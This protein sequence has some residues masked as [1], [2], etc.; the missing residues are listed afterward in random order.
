MAD[1]LIDGENHRRPEN[2]VTSD[3]QSQIVETVDSTSSGRKIWQFETNG[4][5]AASPTVVNGTVFVGSRDESLYAVDAATG[6]KEWEFET[7]GRIVSSPMVAD[8]TV[9]L[10]STDKNVY[11]V[12]VATGTEKWSFETDASIGSSPTVVDE[13]LY[14]ASGGDEGEERLYALDASTGRERWRFETDQWIHTSPVVVNGTVFLGDY[15]NIYAI[16]VATGDEEWRFE[17]E[18]RGGSAL[19]V[20]DGTVFFANGGRSV[21]AVDAATGEERWRTVGLSSPSSPTVINETVF[22]GVERPEYGVSALDAATGREKWHFQTEGSVSA[23]TVVDDTVFF[24]SADDNVYAVDATTGEEA[25]RFQTD[26]SVSAPIVV[27]GV[28]FVGSRDQSLY[29]IDTDSTGSSEDSR[30]RLGIRGHHDTWTEGDPVDQPLRTRKTSFDANDSKVEWRF[31]TDGWVYSSPTVVDGTAFVGAG[32]GF[33]GRGESELEEIDDTNL[34]ALNTATGEAEWRFQTDDE[35]QSSAAVTDGTAY[36]GSYDNSVYAVDATT[37]SEQWQFTTGDGVVSSPTVEENVLFIGSLDGNLY[38]VDATTGEEVWRFET[39]AGIY[40]SPTVID[41]T[42]FVGGLDNNIYAVD[43]AEGE[44]QWRFETTAQV[45]SSPTVSDETLF[46]GSIDGNIYA[47]DASTGEEQWQFRTDAGIYSSPTVAGGTVFVGSWDG[48]LYAVDVDTG[49]KEWHFQTNEAINSS[50]TVAGNTV[51]IG[52]RDENVYAIDVRSGEKEWLFKTDGW[53]YSS[54][55]VANGT[56]FVGSRDNNVYALDVGGEG[57]ST[58]SRVRLGTLGH[59]HEWAGDLGNEETDTSDSRSQSGERLSEV[60]YDLENAEHSR[61]VSVS[62][63]SNGTQYV[64]W[65]IP[66]ADPSRRAVVTPDYELVPPE[67]ARDALLTDVWT[68]SRT[69]YWGDVVEQAERERQAWQILEGLSR[70]GD[71]SADVAAA[72]ALAH[73]SPTGALKHKISALDSAITWRQNAIDNPHREQFSKMAE[74]LGTV[75]WARDEYASTASV[76][77]LSSEALEVIEF[78]IDAYDTVDT[79]T[80]VA[81]VAGVVVAVAENTH[82]VTMGLMAGGAI[83]KATAFQMFPAIATSYAVDEGSRL[84]E[85]NARTAAAGVA[86]NTIRLPILRELDELHEQAV[87]GIIDPPDIVRYH[88]EMATQYQIAAAANSAMATYQ[89]SVD[90]TLLGSGLAQIFGSEDIAETAREMTE[91]YANLSRYSLA[92]LGAGWQLGRQR[93]EESINRELA[94]RDGDSE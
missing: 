46:V 10:G 50:P 84:L 79:I 87:A 35:I 66:D 86:H 65:G 78:A 71:V 41:D 76:E 52:S 16:D 88:I 48:K 25:W 93:F 62:S 55:T 49:Q 43:T 30:V 51:F 33:A 37:G 69:R 19:T 63:G 45:G 72:L 89:D 61:T 77:N 34:Y 57:S 70:A 60:P 39:D 3:Q 24:G 12:D 83:G 92:Q 90:D 81:E 40:S 58:G 29:A 91:H 17:T 47:I 68:E 36:I 38:S 73:V 27:D 23:P 94:D 18:S 32:D 6:D 22:V 53:V 21:C 56:L 11:A 2:R 64:L 13:T 5:I 42:V 74:S 80:D 1:R 8:S 75:Q 44:E 31:E 85:A 14:I 28:L 82:S 4:W 26:G 59:H 20:V 54:P 7:D 67:V 9:F 15:R